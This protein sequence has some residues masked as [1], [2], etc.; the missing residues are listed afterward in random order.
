MLR[1][2]K[3]IVGSL[4][5]VVLAGPAMAAVPIAGLIN[6]GQLAG[7]GTVTSGVVREANWFLNS[8]VRPW[9]SV[10]NG[11]FPQGPWLADTATSRWMTPGRSAG[12]SFDA[13]LDGFYTY[14]LGFDL[15]GF[16]PATASFS[17]RFAADNQVAQIRLNGTAISQGGPGGFA[18]WTSFSASSGF[19]N[20]FNSL[21][22][23]VRN[24]R[25]S[26]GNPTGLR[27]EFQTSS[28][29]AV[30]EPASWTMLIAGFGL[31]GAAARRRTM[32]PTA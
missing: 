14:S 19:I 2:A 10:V 4:A 20:G 12:Q 17:G 29:N 21:E 30:P 9:N 32:L 18:S 23:L 28:I 16:A 13:S 26:S 25:Q 8:E 6:S 11:S 31:V 15:T 24:L 3:F 27:V 7:G 22:F 1:I 5:A